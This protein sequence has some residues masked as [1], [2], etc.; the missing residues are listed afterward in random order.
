M[1]KESLAESNY[2]SPVTVTT[3]E[4]DGAGNIIRTEDKTRTLELSK[5]IRLI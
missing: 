5:R 2:R 1:L 3:A 4:L